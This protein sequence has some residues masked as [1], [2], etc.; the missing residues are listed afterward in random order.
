LTGTVKVLDSTGATL[1]LVASTLNSFGQ[2]GV[3]SDSSDP[4]SLAF[5]PATDGN[6][7]EI[8]VNAAYPQF[9]A[10]VGWA[11]NSSDL[12]VNSGNYISLAAVTSGII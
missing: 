5:T 7:F 12:A 10:A 2:Y 1:G 9:G 4:L 3:S 11:S 6:V 8:A